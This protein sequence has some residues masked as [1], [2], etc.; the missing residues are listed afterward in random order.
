MTYISR[1]EMCD[2]RIVSNIQKD[3]CTRCNILNKL[4]KKHFDKHIKEWVP[5]YN[6]AELNISVK[7]PV[8]DWA[9][10]GV[11]KLLEESEDK[12]WFLDKDVGIPLQKLI[13]EDNN[14]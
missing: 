7:S 6:P 9:T 5:V 12:E 10:P 3:F 11:V 14:E 1:C 8:G 13:S 4:G 2:I